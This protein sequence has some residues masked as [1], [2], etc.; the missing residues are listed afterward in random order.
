M[1]IVEFICAKC[2]FKEDIPLQ[3][4]ELCET[5]DVRGDPT[6]PPRFRCEHCGD[7]QMYPIKYKNHHG[8]TYIYDPSSP[9]KFKTELP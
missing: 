8:F 4:V 2:G 3:A 6:H 7:G 9:Q 1:S 5:L